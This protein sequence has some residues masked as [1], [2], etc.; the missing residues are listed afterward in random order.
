MLLRQLNLEIG[1]NQLARA[2]HLCA[3]LHSMSALKKA[4][5]LAQMAGVS[6]LVE[7]IEAMMETMA[8]SPAPRAETSGRSQREEMSLEQ[9][10]GAAE[11]R[12]KCEWRGGLRDRREAPDRQV[13]RFSS[14]VKKAGTSQERPL[15]GQKSLVSQLR[16][17]A[18]ELGEKL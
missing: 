4:G 6:A 5:Q 14:P 10:I 12:L 3:S 7:R 8:E 18:V 13:E 15:S 16:S 17:T 11:Q 9:R 2:E 1:S